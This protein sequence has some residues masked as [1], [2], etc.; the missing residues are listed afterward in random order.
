MGLILIEKSYDLGVLRS[1]KPAYHMQV[2]RYHSKKIADGK[3]SAN[4][5]ICNIVDN[6]FGRETITLNSCVLAASIPAKAKGSE[7]LRKKR[8][9]ERR[10]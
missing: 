5:Q 9:L 7:F 2:F 6:V 1:A 10:L 3:L 4:L 8:H